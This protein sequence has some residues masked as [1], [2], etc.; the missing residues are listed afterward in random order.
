MTGPAS[1]SP[2]VVVD[3]RGVRCPVNWARAKAI[4]EQVVRGTLVEVLVDDPRSQRDLPVA[5]EAEG[6]AV[7]EI[8]AVSTH[9]RILI[10]K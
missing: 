8:E 6:Y 9:L 1:E 2:R 4:L 3:A 7:L 10:E 5:A